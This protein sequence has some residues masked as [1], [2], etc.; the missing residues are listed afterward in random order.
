M[1]LLGFGLSFLFWAWVGTPNVV[2]SCWFGDF[3]VLF[4]FIVR[5]L[6]GFWGGLGWD[7][8]FLGL[9]WAGLSGLV[10]VRVGFACDS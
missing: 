10:G 1:T 9:R 5:V 2:S 6:V 8:C 3:G 7:V 4:C